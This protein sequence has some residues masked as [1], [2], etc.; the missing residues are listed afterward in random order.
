MASNAIASSDSVFTPLLAAHSQ[1]DGHLTPTSYSSESLNSQV[2]WSVKILLAF[3]ST[4]IP[5]FSLLE[6]HN[7]DFYS[8]IG[9][10]GFQKE[11]SSHTGVF[12]YALSTD[13]IENTASHCCS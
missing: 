9:T 10:Y 12:R 7:Q 5:G 4:I 11:L 6:I 8:F 13:H 1:A 3:T 2:S